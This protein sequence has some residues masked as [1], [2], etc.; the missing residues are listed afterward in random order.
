MNITMETDYAIRIVDFLARQG[1]R[2]GAQTIARKSDV[3]LRFSLKILSKLVAG[4]IIK[5]YKGAQG[6]YELARLPYEI[7]LNDILEIIQGPYEFS[8]C[9]N[10]EHLCPRNA[11]DN[12]C[13]YHHLFADVSDQVRDKL[14]R[15]TISDMLPKQ[16]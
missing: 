2:V 14:L 5:S 7:T 6:G 16:E 8:R 10:S 12:L 1:C 3:T 15:T 13:P 11:E 4:G 9:L